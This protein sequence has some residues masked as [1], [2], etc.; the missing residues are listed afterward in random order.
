MS[1][2]TPFPKRCAQ[3]SMK[4]HIRHGISNY[5][6]KVPWDELMLPELFIRRVCASVTT[7]SGR[8]VHIGMTQY[9][10]S[11]CRLS[12]VGTKEPLN[13]W[14]SLDGEKLRCVGIEFM[15]NSCPLCV[16]SGR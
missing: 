4:P 5:H 6:Q 10:A 13:W 8:G 11:G 12:E 9:G 1:R 2:P 16:V 14:A 3:T 15:D 7:V